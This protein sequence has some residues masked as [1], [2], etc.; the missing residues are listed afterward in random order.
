M[1]PVGIVLQPDLGS[2]AFSVISMHPVRSWCGW[3]FSDSFSFVQL[4][5]LEQICGQVQFVD[6]SCGALRESVDASPNRQ[7]HFGVG[8]RWRLPVL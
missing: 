5:S 6:V 1:Q 3:S 8:P 2:V 7:P 4:S